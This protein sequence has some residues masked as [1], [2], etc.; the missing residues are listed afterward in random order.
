MDT[1]VG[2]LQ[3]KEIVNVKDGA[4]LGFVD[5]VLIDTETAAVKSLVVYGRARFFGLMGRRPDLSIPWEKIDVI[6]EDTILV[7]VES[8]PYEPPKRFKWSEF[9]NGG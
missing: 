1:K 9:W 2:D 6:G 4:K 3:H 7:S 8:L 5:D